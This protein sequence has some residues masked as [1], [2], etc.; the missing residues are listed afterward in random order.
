M[1][2]LNFKKR[3]LIVKQKI[4]G[5]TVSKIALAQGVSDRA[6]RE[7]MQK[8]RNY[9]WEGLKDQKTGRPETKLNENAETVIVK[10]HRSETSGIL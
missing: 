9:S 10:N 6:I 5:I 3:V 1:Y 4:K 7:I 2:K 8:Y